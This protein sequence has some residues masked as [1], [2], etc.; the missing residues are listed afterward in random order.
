VAH[1]GAL[2]I[3]AMA[4]D[5]QGTMQVVKLFAIEP[6]CLLAAPAKPI[7]PCRLAQ[8]DAFLA[9]MLLN[10]EF[11]SFII[12][13]GLKSLNLCA[14][15]VLHCSTPWGTRGM[16]IFHFRRWGEIENQFQL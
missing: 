10:E 9:F 8:H 15:T 6:D 11:D 1:F 4:R 2:P 12:A 3:D 13:G 5:R 14:L 16:L 7:C